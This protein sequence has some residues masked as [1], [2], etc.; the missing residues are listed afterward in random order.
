MK[1]PLVN[2]PSATQGAV[3]AEQWNN[4]RR[5]E[6][7]NFYRDNVFGPL[8][9]KPERVEFTV[10]IEDEVFSGIATR[11]LVLV[12]LFNQGKRYNFEVI[13]F[14]PKKLQAVPGV[15][16]L[17]F[18]DPFGKQAHRWPFEMICRRGWAVATAARNSIFFDSSDR[19][20]ESVWKIF[21]DNCQ[22]ERQYTAISA[23]AFGYRILLQLLQAQPEVDSSR[24][25]AHG[26]SRL[27]KTALW[28]GA[29][30]PE[31]AGIVSNDSGCAGAA[32]YR[33]KEGETLDRIVSVFPH[34]FRA[35]FE[36]F[37]SMTAEKLP[38]DQHWLLSLVAPRPLLVASAFEDSWADPVNE[39]RSTVCAGETYRLFGAEGLPDNSQFPAV[40][41]TQFGD[42]VGYYCRSGA[43]DVTSFDWNSVLDFFDSRLK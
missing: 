20:G 1:P 37:S 19:R 6:I 21:A 25:I 40:N 43:H 35:E 31:F 18:E 41:E 14:V 3:S 11:R 30:I 8:P 26:H 15:V 23:W 12:E 2:L 16:A 28:A 22:Y 32:L 42:L 5:Q 13:V 29:N 9:P 36:Q 38:F 33:G 7:L 27:G 17:Y 10:R 24:I 4:S 39:W 34:W